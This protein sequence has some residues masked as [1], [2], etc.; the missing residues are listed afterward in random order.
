MNIVYTAKRVGD[1]VKHTLS[2]NKERFAT[3]LEEIKYKGNDVNIELFKFQSNSY[4]KKLLHGQFFF[5]KLLPEGFDK[6]NLLRGHTISMSACDMFAKIKLAL[7]S[8]SDA[9]YND[10]LST[11]PDLKRTYKCRDKAQSNS[12]AVC[13]VI[14]EILS[15]AFQISVTAERTGRGVSKT[16]K[17][18]INAFIWT[19]L[20]ERYNPNCLTR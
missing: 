8:M 4:F 20:I 3:R 19:N 6:R 2:E 13:R 10:S 7:A 11:F 15:T 5:E 12:T 1:L 17:R 9:K 16:N 18:C 14:Q